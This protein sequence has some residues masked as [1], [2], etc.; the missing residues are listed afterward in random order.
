MKFLHWQNVYVEINL[1]QIYIFIISFESDD[2]IYC[3]ISEVKIHDDTIKQVENKKEDL[4]YIALYKY[5]YYDDGKFVK[6][7]IPLKG[8][9]TVK[10][11]ITVEFNE[12]SFFVYVRRLGSSNYRFGVNKLMYPIFNNDS[13]FIVKTDEILI[14]LHKKK[15]DEHWSYLYKVKMIGD[16]E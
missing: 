14:K 5:T 16:D 1:E 11:N 10:D 9:S 7:I 2:D 8:V 15:M 4:N 6:V 3:I 13:A 12:R